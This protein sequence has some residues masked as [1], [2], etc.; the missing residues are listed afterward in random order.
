MAFGALRMQTFVFGAIVVCLSQICFVSC[1]GG[2]ANAT[3]VA[4]AADTTATPQPPP[5]TVAA[6]ATAATTLAHAVESE[7]RSVQTQTKT[8]LDQPVFF[9]ML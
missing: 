9:F 6:A 5:T 4:G 7:Y 2:A 8:N 3:T 1:G